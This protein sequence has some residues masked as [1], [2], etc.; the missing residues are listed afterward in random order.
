MCQCQLLCQTTINLWRDFCQACVALLYRT[1]DLH[2]LETQQEQ[3]R[4]ELSHY[5]QQ[6]KERPNDSKPARMAFGAEFYSLVQRLSCERKTEYESIRGIGCQ[7][8]RRETLQQTISKDLS[9][10]SKKCIC[11]QS[12]HDT[13]LS[14][15]TCTW[16]TYCCRLH[17]KTCKDAYEQ[18]S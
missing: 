13:G 11:C 5:L 15:T 17:M 4:Q 3:R 16:S 9:A 1:A 7:T 12:V 6:L 8:I 10:L 2:S 18:K 14:G